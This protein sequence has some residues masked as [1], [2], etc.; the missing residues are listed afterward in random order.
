MYTIT[1]AFNDFYLPILS[2][3]RVE[4]GLLVYRLILI[5]YYRITLL[6]MEILNC[7][8]YPPPIKIIY[9]AIFCHLQLLMQL[10]YVCASNSYP[11]HKMIVGGSIVQ[12]CK[13]LPC[14]SIVMMFQ[15]LIA[16]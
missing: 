14:L 7:S 13:G 16:N 3:W 12:V 8:H 2:R 10:L 4:V 1:I 5:K 11:V 9:S 15:N 6:S